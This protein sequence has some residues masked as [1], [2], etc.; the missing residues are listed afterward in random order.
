M[1]RTIRNCR[2][3]INQNGCVNVYVGHYSDGFNLEIIKCMA[4]LSWLA[5]GAVLSLYIKDP[6]RSGDRLTGADIR[7]T[8][9]SRLD[10]TSFHRP[11]PLVGRIFWLLWG[12][13]ANRKI[14]VIVGYDRRIPA[15][16]QLIVM[17]T[18]G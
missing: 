7:Y 14:M 9:G 11:A 8:N 10:R 18:Y 12:S 17:D 16:H 4:T 2:V 6:N 5:D 15:D 3:Y 13:G 1:F